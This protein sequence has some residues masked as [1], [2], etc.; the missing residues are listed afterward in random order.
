VADELSEMYDIA[1]VGAGPVGIFAAYYAG[2]RGLRCVVMDS[3]D[4][5]GGQISAM[6]PAKPIFDVAGFPSVLGR[7]LIAGLLAQ[8]G[9]FDTKY[10]LGTSVVELNQPSNDHGGKWFELV[11]SDGHEVIARSVLITGGIG[12]FQPRVHRVCAPFEGRGVDYYV[13]SLDPYRDRDVVIIGGGDSAV[14]WALTLLP[15]ARSTTLVHRRGTFR[16]HEH[17]VR[18]M[19]SSSIDVVTDAEVVAVRGDDCLESV[20]VRAGDDERAIKCQKLITALGFIAALGPMLTWGMDI[21]DHRHIVVD[22]TMSS[23]IPGVFAAG[24]ITAY[25][26]KV[27]LIVVGFGEAATAVNNAAHYLDPRAEIFPGHSTEGRQFEPARKEM[28]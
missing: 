9:Q 12:R 16:A 5:P 17:S 13:Q 2:F 22:S 14:D 23:S 18:T 3:L 27:R 7:D 28:A 10:L 25:P 4:Q 15:V 21:E 19:M 6:Y 20:V 1:I 11:S 24:D 26:G 8:A